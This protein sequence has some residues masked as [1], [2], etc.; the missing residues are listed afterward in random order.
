MY[1]KIFPFSGCQLCAAFL[2]LFSPLFDTISLFSVLKTQ[3]QFAHRTEGKPPGLVAITKST[4]QKH[5]IKGFYS[6]VGALVAGNSLKAGVR[7]LSYDKFKKM[8]V[9]QDVSPS[10]FWWWKME[11]LR[12]RRWKN[13]ALTLALDCCSLADFLSRC[14]QGKL[15]GPRSLLGKIAFSLK[16][17]L[18]ARPILIQCSRISWTWCRNDGSSFRGYTFRNHQVRLNSRC[19]QLICD[20]DP[21]FQLSARPT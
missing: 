5:G 7:F 21:L 1:V 3:A 12:D 10:N 6:G 4:F 15:S 13:D 11:V 16:W 20:D 19:T 9:D 2:T 17:Q 8:L 18:P 14:S